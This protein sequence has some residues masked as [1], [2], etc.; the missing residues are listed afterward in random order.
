MSA[1]R[2]TAYLSLGSNI[3]PRLA[4]LEQAVARLRE[5]PGIEV[6]RVSRHVTTAPWGFS[7]DNEFINQAVEVVTTLSPEALLEAL[8]TVERTIDPSPHRDRD[9]GY[10]DRRIDIDMIAYGDTVLSTD[11]L[12]L[13]HPRAHLRDFVLIPMAE[14]APSWRHPL[15]GL[16]A[17]QLLE[18]LKCDLH[19]S[20]NQV[21]IS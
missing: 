11:S 16:T 14:I 3:E 20:D 10:I 2:V 19:K 9:G 5:W 4:S 17:S 18:R 1:K 8:Q 6:S 7:S 15:S 21:L 12:T 13:P